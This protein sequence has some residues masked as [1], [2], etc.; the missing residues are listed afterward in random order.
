MGSPFYESARVSDFNLAGILKQV[1]VSESYIRSIIFLAYPDIHGLCFF[2]LL[3]RGLSLAGLPCKNNGFVQADACQDLHREKI[4]D[5]LG[6]FDLCINQCFFLLSRFANEADSDI[7][8]ESNRGSNKTA[9]LS[10]FHS[11]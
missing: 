8:I 10:S 6:F 4:E 7:N 1:C 5:Y 11:F 2:G 9:E 3:T